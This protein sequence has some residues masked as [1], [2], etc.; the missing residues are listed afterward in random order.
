[1]PVSD[2]TDSAEQQGWMSWA[3]S[4][5]PQITPSADSGTSDARRMAK[6]IEITILDIG[7]YIMRASVVFKVLMFIYLI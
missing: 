1:M 3:W 7:A 2:S 4:F 5:V 6:K